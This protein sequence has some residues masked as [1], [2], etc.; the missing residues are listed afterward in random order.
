MTR[1]SKITRR[2]A[3]QA[4]CATLAA[5]AP[6]AITSTALGGANKAPASDRIT[7]AHIGVGNRG[8][9][10][11]RGVYGLPDA[12]IVAVAD[13]FENRRASKATVCKGKAYQ[14][15][16]DILARDDIDAVVI[17]TPDHQHVPLAI[18]AARA[19]KSAYVEKPL[20][21]S[22]EQDLA[23][24]KA[25]DKSGTV[26]QYGTQQRSMAHCH[27]GCELV[28]RGAIGKIHTIEVDCPNGGTGG[29]TKEEAVPQGLDYNMWLGPAPL[30]PYTRDRCKPPGS[31]WIYD[32]SIGYLGGWG[33]HPLDIMVWGC[34][35]DLKGPIVVEGT[36]VVPTDGLYDAVYN[37]D[38]KIQLGDVRLVFRPGPE[39]TRFIGA[40]GWI[41]VARAGN[42]NQASDPDLLATKLDAEPM[43]LLVSKN[44]QGNF[45]EAV[46]Q[47]KPAAAVSHLR[48]AVR[49]DLISHL[50]DIAVRSG[51]RVVWDPVAEKLTEGNSR[52]RSMLQRPMRKPWTL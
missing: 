1:T 42:R 43:R 48:D 14:D 5:V 7:I 3:L 29:S 36:G 20:G 51:E 4:G 37:W 22:I 32:Q 25:F 52:A 24:R 40:D 2:Q 11:F 46:K 23:C 15:Y 30:K 39:R 10:L 12:Q 18:Q 31:Y 50:C 34:D 19:G 9:S 13:C 8:S 33:A 35:A 26:F 21:L 27:L 47:G 49:S 38:M 16:H 28:R 44:H 17:A 45:V 41:Q 6:Y